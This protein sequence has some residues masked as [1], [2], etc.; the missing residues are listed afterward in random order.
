MMN[1][2]DPIQ[3]AGGRPVEDRLKPVVK[4]LSWIPSIVFIVLI[5]S[6]ILYTLTP[7]IQPSK[8]SSVFDAVAG[9][10]ARLLAAVY[11]SYF[12][13]QL[14]TFNVVCLVMLAAF[15]LYMLSPLPLGYGLATAY[16]TGIIAY[17]AGALITGFLS[18]I[19]RFWAGGVAEP[20]PMTPSYGFG[21][22]D[23][24]MAGLLFLLY[25]SG[26]LVMLI[27]RWASGQAPAML[28]IIAAV[29]GLTLLSMWLDRGQS[30]IAGAYR[31]PEKALLKYS[32]LGG[33]LGVIAGAL[34][35]RHKTGHVGLLASVILASAAGL[36]ILLGGLIA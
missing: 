13:S 11:R 24:F 34:I 20:A 33:G 31:L 27:W 1:R 7:V 18:G 35:L 15:L 17:F 19:G 2:V 5:L 26:K 23:F 4:L 12:P 21:V 25:M 8:P 32:A 30:R 14:N 36:F 10:L 16:V 6:L 29:N 22:G 3:P 28:I 9:W